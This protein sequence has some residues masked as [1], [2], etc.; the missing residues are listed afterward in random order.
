MYQ[1]LLI[2][3][4]NIG[5]LYDLEN[6]DVLTHAKAY[7]QHP[8]FSLTVFD[9][10]KEL[11]TR[12][13]NAHKAA[14]AQPIEE[15]YLKQFHCVSVCSPTQTHASWL[16][17]AIQ[18]SV[19]IVICEKP[20]SNNSEEL[21]ALAASHMRGNTKILVNYIRRFQPAYMALKQNISDWL[22]QETLTNVAIRYQRGFINNAS[23]AFDLLQFLFNKS[24]NLE[25]V[26]ISHAINDHFPHDPT[27]TLTSTWD[28][29]GF[30]AMGLTN[31]QFSH[32]E[33][34]LYFHTRKIMITDAGKTI[35]I[36]EAPVIETFLQSPG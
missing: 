9:P 8:G 7:T 29:A 31:V 34:D 16:H 1:A 19:P 36:L 33:I 12:I 35:R 4:G 13:A 11:E 20:V 25:Q 6:Q 5:A 15:A 18:A 10:D 32:F 3:C 28:Q 22:Q 21:T 30:N 24:I 26:Q 27:L 23:H 2:G 17:L 14:I